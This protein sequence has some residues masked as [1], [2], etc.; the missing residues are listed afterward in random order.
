MAGYSLAEDGCK[1]FRPCQPQHAAPH[2]QGNVAEE[3]GGVVRKHGDTFG[4]RHHA[5]FLHSLASAGKA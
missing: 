2:H 5:A 1:R 3:L 4:R